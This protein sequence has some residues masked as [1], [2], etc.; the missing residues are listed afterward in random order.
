[1]KPFV[2]IE[3]VSASDHNVDVEEELAGKIDNKVEE[4][5][6]EKIPNEENVRQQILDS[7]KKKEKI[8]FL[9]NDE[10]VAHVGPDFYS[11]KRE[12]EIIP[13]LAVADSSADLDAPESEGFPYRKPLKEVF[14]DLFK[15]GFSPRKI[16]LDRNTGL[17]KDNLK[18]MPDSKRQRMSRGKLREIIDNGDNYWPNQ[19][20]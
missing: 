14:K 6:G 10:N 5:V 13:E 7:Y 11:D 1:M 19:E 12:K 3:E 15:Y 9:Q 16:A 2:P 17:E 4:T 8:G 20:N 18:T